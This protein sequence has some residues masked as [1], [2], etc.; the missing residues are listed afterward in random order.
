[1]PLGKLCI[2]RSG[3]LTGSRGSLPEAGG[4]AFFGDVG[5]PVRSSLPCYSSS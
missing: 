3:E 2:V 5:F 4:F 1:M